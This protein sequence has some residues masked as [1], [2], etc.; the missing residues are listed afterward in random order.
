MGVRWAAWVSA[1][2]LTLALLGGCAGRD[3]GPVTAVGWTSAGDV[4]LVRDAYD[5]A[6]VLWTGPRGGRL[7]A[8]SL[9]RVCSGVTVMSIFALAAPKIGLVVSCGGNDPRVAF[10]SFDPLTLQGQ[11]LAAVAS[12]NLPLLSGYGGGVWS[13]P[14]RSALIEYTT[15]GCA[16]LG[17][18]TGATVHPLDI[19]VV[20][21]GGSLRLADA[22][23]E[24]GGAGCAARSLARAVSLSPHGRYLGFFVHVCATPCAGPMPDARP[25]PVAVDEIWQVVVQ[26][27][28]NG[29]VTVPGARFRWPLNTAMTDEGVLVISAGQGDEAGLYRCRITTCDTPIRLANGRFGSVHIRPDGDE[30]IALRQGTDEPTFIPLGR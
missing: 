21:P 13:E 11:A 15:L 12:A 3:R 10:V 7:Q 17:T 16:G 9:G 5:E 14:D 1:L 6:A 29:T 22:L 24:V 19:D 26:D 23:P 18:L 28:I 20:L 8:V 4:V 2:G 30:I 25:G 27:R